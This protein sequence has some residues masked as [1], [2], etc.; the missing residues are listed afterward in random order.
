[1]ENWK[2][3]EGKDI[4][5]D[6]NWLRHIKSLTENEKKKIPEEFLNEEE[7]L[8]LAIKEKYKLTDDTFEQLVTLSR[9]DKQ[10]AK[11]L[12]L[13]D[14]I[15]DANLKYAKQFKSRKALK[16][17]DITHLDKIAST[18]FK[19]LVFTTEKHEELKEK[20]K[21]ETKAAEEG[22]EV[23]KKEKNITFKF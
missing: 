5:G 16:P 14:M 21:E 3:K 2:T 4:K 13:L 15:S 10:I 17:V 1:M 18:T 8:C 11:D 23:E 12:L 6:S 19:R 9:G 22:R 7:K 20:I